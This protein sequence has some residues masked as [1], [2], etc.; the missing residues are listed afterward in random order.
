M[1]LSDVDTTYTS[2]RHYHKE[3]ATSNRHSLQKSSRLLCLVCHKLGGLTYDELE[4][5][6]M[7]I[8]GPYHAIKNTLTCEVFHTWLFNS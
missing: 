5:V 3:L 6:N 4:Y 8:L 7:Y 1:I 2:C